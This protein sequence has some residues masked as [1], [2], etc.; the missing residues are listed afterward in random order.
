M[1]VVCRVSLFSVLSDAS[2]QSLAVLSASRWARQS[3][4]SSSAGGR[5]AHKAVVLVVLLVCVRFLAHA[6]VA[7]V[8]VRQGGSLRNVTACTPHTPSPPS[9]S[10]PQYDMHPP[11]KHTSNRSSTL[12]G[13]T[14]ASTPSSAPA[15][16]QQCPVRCCQAHWL[17]ALPPLC[18][19]PA[20]SMILH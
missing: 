6:H 9:T 2:A 8:R 11:P 14:L 20:G 4:C 18:T 1:C 5:L 10:T 17:S 16:P 7:V 19:I 12:C 15:V 13:A 3:R